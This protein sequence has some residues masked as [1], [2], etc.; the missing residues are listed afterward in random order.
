MALVADIVGTIDPEF[1]LQLRKHDTPYQLLCECKRKYK[2]SEHETEQAVLVKWHKLQ[3]APNI[4]N[5][6]GWIMKWENVFAEGKE[7]NLPDMVEWRAR[8]K[9]LDVIESHVASNYAVTIKAQVVNPDFKLT[10]N[11]LCKQFVDWWK[12]N[13]NM[14]KQARGKH[15]AFSV[16]QDEKAA[17]VK[18]TLRGRDSKGKYTH[19][20]CGTDKHTLTR[21]PYV[22]HDLRPAN[23]RGDEETQWKVDKEVESR[24]G[25]AAYVNKAKKE[26]TE[27]MPKSS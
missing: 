1:L 24:P 19:C 8:D 3:T 15:G 25:L 7:L 11:D 20:I 10:F 4:A 2:P 9:L 12:R 5:I 27:G 6:E 18:P 26:R 21:C 14:N 16:G 22:M 17:D 23:W 13:G